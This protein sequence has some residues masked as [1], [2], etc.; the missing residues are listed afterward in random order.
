[1]FWAVKYLKET[2]RFEIFQMKFHRYISHYLQ[3]AKRT[4]RP[5]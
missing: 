1:V 4:Y 5:A 3:L 2:V